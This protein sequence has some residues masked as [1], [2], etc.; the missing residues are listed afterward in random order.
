MRNKVMRSA[1]FLLGMCLVLCIFGTAVDASSDK[2]RPGEILVKYKTGITAK[3][4]SAALGGRL[5]RSL[6]RIG[7]HRV[8]LKAGQSVEDA[9]AKFGKNRNVVWA[10]P[11]HI[12]RLMNTMPNDEW[13]EGQEFCIPELE[14]CIPMGGQW[15]LYNP[16]GRRDIHAPEAWDI[17]RGSA[18]TIIAVV[19]TGVQSY[20][21]DLSGRVLEGYNVFDGSTDADDDQ[22]HGTSVASIAA[23]NTNNEDGIAGV[24]WNA[25]ILPVKVLNSD[26]EGDEFG[27]AQ[28]MIWAVDHGAKILNLSFGA[29]ETA[30]V[31]EDAANYA[32]NAGCVIVAASGNS[33]YDD[34]IN[35]CYPAH[36][37]VCISVGA[38]NEYDQ[39]CSPMDWLIGGSD[40]GDE[41]DVM[42]PGNNIYAAVPGYYDEWFGEWTE[43]EATSGTSAATPFV[44]GLAGLIWAHNPTWTNQQVRDQIERTCDD[45]GS[46]GW[47]RYTGW[48]RIN[49]YRALTEAPT[50][51]G[52]IGDALAQPDGTSVSLSGKVVTAGT[53]N[54]ADADRFYVEESDRSAG[55]MVYCGSG[56]T[57]SADIGDKVRI[58][59]MLS[60]VGGERALTNPRVTPDGTG[61]VPRAL[62]MPARSIGGVLP[63][64]G[65]ETPAVG[66]RNVGLL[67]K[68]WGWVKSSSW[69][70][71]Y[72][73]DGS[74]LRDGSGYQG[75]KIYTGGLTKPLVGQ[76]VSITGICS[77]ET[78][79]QTQVRIPIVRARVQSDIVRLH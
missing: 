15:G 67:T 34:A 16:E 59:G 57:I 13:F 31:L 78:P 79:P 2:V 56:S 18:S 55:I 19:D 21:W 9:V 47:D 28:G 8:K 11:N 45:I 6:P 26:G 64:Y 77:V 25:M 38:S 43:Y 32:W 52:S 54:F 73:D 44:A 75:L 65:G 41:L 14:I 69:N 48:G 36:Y 27:V 51:Y 10:G 39:R 61:D 49:A 22:G 29:Y 35:P 76:F 74:A 37:P 12:V 72:I 46:P 42:A 68:T 50:T 70:Y 30:Q 66:L 63:S 71:I 60:V 24:D 20:H 58:T 7:V 23:A 5:D 4:M 40:Y 53:S 1:I 17:E 33:N 62:G 3:A